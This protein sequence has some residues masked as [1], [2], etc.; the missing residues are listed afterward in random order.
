M[1]RG[2]DGVEP[3]GFFTLKIMYFMSQ[4][5]FVKTTNIQFGLA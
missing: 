3:A 2:G 1:E 4:S 5:L